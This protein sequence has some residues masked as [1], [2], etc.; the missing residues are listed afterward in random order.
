MCNDAARKA[1][2]AAAEKLGSKSELA[3]HFGVPRQAVQNWQDRQVPAKYVL[4]LEKLSGI[5]RCELRPDVFGSKKCA[6]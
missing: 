5:S 3:R 1:V 6:A 2:E 4:V